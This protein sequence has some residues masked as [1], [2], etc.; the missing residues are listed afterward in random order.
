MRHAPLVFLVAPLCFFLIGAT[1]IAAAATP[2][3]L[4]DR[5]EKWRVANVLHGYSQNGITIDFKGK[6]SRVL[7]PDPDYVTVETIAIDLKRLNVPMDEFQQKLETSLKQSKRKQ[8]QEE[9]MKEH[10]NQLS[11]QNSSKTDVYPPSSSPKRPPNTAKIVRKQTNPACRES[12][13]KVR[14]DK[15]E[16]L[17]ET[18]P[19]SYS[20]QK[21]LLESSLKAYDY[22]CSIK[23]TPD[24][25][26]LLKRLHDTYY[27]SY[28][29]IKRLYDN[30]MKDLQSLR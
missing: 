21:R 12:R 3:E 5:Y 24:S 19:G 2:Q 30:N 1:D 18:Y 28:A 10:F 14:T 8:K 13:S 9:R 20:L 27:P 25:D 4:I 29:L 7:H 26:R 6:K 22:I 15:L 11:S 16:N 17:K 23:S